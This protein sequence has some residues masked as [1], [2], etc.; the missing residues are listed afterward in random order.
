MGYIENSYTNSNNGGSV[1][2]QDSLWQMKMAA[3][4]GA[5]IPPAH[6]QHQV[7]T[8]QLCVTIQRI[9][10]KITFFSLGYVTSAYECQTIY[11]RCGKTIFY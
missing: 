2:S 1:N 7:S 9:Q 8:Y 3:A 5:P 6:T 4:G 10:I 11:H